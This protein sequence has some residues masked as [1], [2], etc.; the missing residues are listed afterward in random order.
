MS[1]ALYVDLPTLRVIVQ[2]FPLSQ[3]QGC[4]QMNVKVPPMLYEG[5]VSLDL[6]NCREIMHL[7]DIKQTVH[8]RSPYRWSPKKHLFCFSQLMR[9]PTFSINYSY[10]LEFLADISFWIAQYVGPCVTSDCFYFQHVG[11]AL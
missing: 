10:A 5:K 9:L 7:S 11:N 6:W 2:P 1:C 4:H 3:Y 8:N